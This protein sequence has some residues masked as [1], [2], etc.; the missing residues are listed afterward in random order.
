MSQ[1]EISSARASV[2]HGGSRASSRLSRLNEITF[3]LM[4]AVLVLSPIP[5]GSTRGFFWGLLAFVVG[6]WALIYTLG[7]LQI[8]QGVRIGLEI[9]ALPILAMAVFCFW[10]L[11]QI[12][13][14]GLVP[15]Q[16]SG[17][18]IQPSAT[19]SVTPDATLMML[20]RQLTYGLFFLLMLQASANEARRR[21][22][23]DI[24][25]AV[26]VA[27]GIYGLVSLQSGDTIL[28]LEKWAYQGY[29]TATFINR[30]SFATFL[31]MGGTLA[32][33]RLGKLLADASLHH[34]HDGKLR[35]LRGDLL[36]YG[37]A[38]V[39][40]VVVVLSTGSRMG[41]FVTVV[42][43][44]VSSAI[45][46][47]RSRRLAFLSL[48]VP[49]AVVAFM[50]ILV[51]YGGALLER[52]G[53]LESSADVRSDL[54]WQIW[55]MITQRPLVGFG[56]GSFELAFPIVHQ[57]PVSSD[58][59]WSKAHDTYLALWS[60]MGLVFG[61]LPLLAIGFIAAKLVIAVARKRGNLETQAIALGVLAVGGIHSLVDFSLEIP[62]NTFLFLALLAA[63]AA[64]TV[65]LKVTS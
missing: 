28:G 23:F 65:N 24:L 56:G 35:N 58:L 22:M 62:A 20:I 48:L 50:A 41:L 55:E 19:I 39:F 40:L 38:Y 25:L 4:L 15:L 1:I 42:G 64:S 10:L 57:A 52:L 9:F 33:A 17:G 16:L 53:S 29:A 5:F 27:Y 46:L 45:A 43:A 21:M 6:I 61:S 63:G 51:V 49:L 37:L 36:I 59:V 18:V 34:A 26:T 31:A 30:N 8:R 47:R 32:A 11:V 14:L 12:L 54:Y 7:V 44:I 60:E 2:R 3:W 13:P